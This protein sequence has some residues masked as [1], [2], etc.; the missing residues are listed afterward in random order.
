MCISNN[1]SEQVS[2]YSKYYC[3]WCPNFEVQLNLEILLCDL[4][5]EAVGIWLSYL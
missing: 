2:I 1:G 5:Q 4:L 3:E